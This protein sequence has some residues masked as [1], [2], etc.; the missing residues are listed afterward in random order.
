MFQEL[1]LDS[2]KW[3]VNFDGTISPVARVA[4]ETQRYR[5]LVLGMGTKNNLT[6]VNH[7]NKAARLELKMVQNFRRLPVTGLA[8]TSADERETCSLR[9]VSHGGGALALV[10]GE[11]SKFL[12]NDV[13]KLTAGSE[14]SAVRV[15]FEQTEDDKEAVHIRLAECDRL[16][17]GPIQA[18][19]VA[20][21]NFEVGTQVL[22][23][24]YFRGDNQKF[25][26]NEDGTISP[27]KAVKLAL[28]FKYDEQEIE[29]VPLDD[30]NKNRQLIVT[31][32]T[33]DTKKCAL[34]ERNL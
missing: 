18:F 19:D 1:G 28:G 29:P 22:T 5:G 20:G 14:E 11:P 32:D 16:Q 10:H 24:Y 33:G 23:Y 25:I 2:Q 8:L 13:I 4:G 12:G 27:A 21:G 15:I 3:E 6:L 9:L 17:S 7:G 26:L 30:S 34:P 31:E